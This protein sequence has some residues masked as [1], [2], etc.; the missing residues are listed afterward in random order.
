MSANL[1][2]LDQLTLAYGG[3]RVSQPLTLQIQAG[4]KVAVIGRS[5]VGKTTLLR[6]LR[7]QQSLEVAWCPQHPGLVPPLSVFHNVFM[8]RLGRHSAAFNL[9]NLVYPLKRMREEVLA[10]V[11]PLGLSNLLMTPVE[12][13][14]G[15]QQSRVNLA[16]ALYQQRS[17]FIGDEPVAS[18][19]EVMAETLLDEI[20]RRHETVIIALHDVALAMKFSDR[21]V[22]LQDGKI[23]LDAPTQTLEAGQLIRI[24]QDT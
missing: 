22:G 23:A 1:F 18:V 11:A 7:Q 4:E 2:T 10:I 19:D 24:Y 20:C 17:V 9:L 5:G 12:K 15:G 14:S 21:I 8:G 13:L 16:R 3:H 6:T